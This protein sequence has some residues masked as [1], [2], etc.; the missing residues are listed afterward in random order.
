VI[1]TSVPNF[2]EIQNTWYNPFAHLAW[3]EPTLT[4]YQ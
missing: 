3:N 1:S 4:D 2:I